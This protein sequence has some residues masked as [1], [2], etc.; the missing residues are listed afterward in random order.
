MR[1]LF[2]MLFF[3]MGLVACTATPKTAVLQ[4]NQVANFDQNTRLNLQQDDISELTLS[5]L[6]RAI[7][8]RAA[9]IVIEPRG[10]V[11]SALAVHAANR[12]LRFRQ[13]YQIA[14]PAPAIESGI[15]QRLN[16]RYGWTMK[17][18]SHSQ[19]RQ[20]LDLDIKSTQWRT[21]YAFLRQA[22]V[23]DYE[24]DMHLS[25]AGKTL[26][27]GRCVYRTPAE[28][29]VLHFKTVLAQRGAWFRE[30]TDRLIKHCVATL[31]K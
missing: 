4:P 22:Y 25:Y 26:A 1:R 27:H 14:D 20:V 21:R 15:A 30:E 6:Q 10:V 23:I 3:L 28:K 11:A 19:V 7:L 24:A 13:Q 12:G 2:L 31:L 8:G 18:P 9:A 17:Q 5:N 29:Q 16:K